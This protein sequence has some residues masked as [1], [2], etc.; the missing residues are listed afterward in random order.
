MIKNDLTYQL[1]TTTNEI[2]QMHIRN[3]QKYLRY[4]ELK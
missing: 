1:E 3:Q 2:Q 4:E